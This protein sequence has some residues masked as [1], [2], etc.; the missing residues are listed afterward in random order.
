MGKEMKSDMG[1]ET[2]KAVGPTAPTAPA[3]PGATGER[4]LDAACEV[5]LEKG[6]AGARMQEIAARA[7]I[8]KAL[9]HYYFRSKEELYRQA[10]T[11]E[12]TVFFRELV[13]SVR[14]AGDMETFIRS[15]I[16]NYID[17]LSRN[18][19]VVRFLTWEIGSGGPVA[20]NVI[21][22]IVQGNEGGPIYP[23][24][25]ETFSKGVRAGAI[26]PVD[27]QHLIFNL[28][29]MCIYVFLAAPIL[30]AVFPEIDPS[31]EKFIEKRK[32]EIFDLVWNG[33]KA[34]KG[35]NDVQD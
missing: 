17:R 5:F 24:F 25:R 30:T 11:R 27:P 28:I 1:P 35:G 15:F 29:G 13:E 7:G 33:I 32:R 9:L 31:D 3:G 22:G 14:P 10:L 26:R 21:A 23:V 20:R 16:D 19:Q 4:I 6:K 2:E 12:L 34:E 8:N 18:P